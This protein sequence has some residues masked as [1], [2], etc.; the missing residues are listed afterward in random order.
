[1]DENCFNWSTG[2]YAVTDGRW[3]GASREVIAFY[4][5]PR[6]FLNTNDAYIFMK[7]SYDPESQNLSGLRELLKGR[8][9]ENKYADVN[10]MLYGGDY[11]YVIM[12]AAKISGV[13]PYIL[14]S[15]IIQEQG[16]NGTVFTDGTLSYN[17]VTVYNFFN[18][19]V[20]GTTEAEK[21]TNGAKFAFNM[22]WT[23][24]SAA[25]IGGAQRYANG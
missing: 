6:N 8:F 16:S 23:T 12:E 22:G 25:I 14:A 4:M 2:A 1:M 21:R 9:L 11:A 17:G 3:Y 20:T 7:Q 5:D 24:R 19:G 18:M 10:D 15:T 13:S